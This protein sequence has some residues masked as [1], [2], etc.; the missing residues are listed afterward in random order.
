MKLKFVLLLVFGL[1]STIAANPAVATG[2]AITLWQLQPA[3]SAAQQPAPAHST[4]HIALSLDPK[5]LS[6]IKAQT[7]VAIAVPLFHQ[8]LQL[9]VNRV[10][11]HDKQRT[12]HAANGSRRMI[13]TTDGSHTFATVITERGNWSISGKDS[14]AM[15]YQSHAPAHQ[16]TTAEKDYLIAPPQQPVLKKKRPQQQSADVN[17][18]TVAIVDAYILYNDAAAQLYGSNSGALTRINHI[19][20]V[21]NDI[22]R[23]SNVNIELNALR[24]DKVDYPQSFNTT[25]ALNHATGESE[26]S[27]FAEQ[28]QIRDAI[29]ADV[30]ILLRPY[31]DDGICGQAWVNNSFNSTYYMVSHTSIDC[32][33]EVNAHELG[34]NMGLL[35][36]RKQG[37][38]G[39][40]F[41]FALGHGVDASFTTVMAYP[42]AFDGAQRLFK[43]SSPDLDCSGQPCG[44]DRN[45]SVNGADAVYALN[46][47]RFD[48][49]AVAERGPA[50][51]SLN[52]ELTGATSAAIVSSSGHGGLAPYT[53]SQLELGS[54][55]S[56]SA[57]ASADGVPFLAW[58][59]CDSSSGL[60]CS[61]TVRGI[62]EVSAIYSEMPASLAEAVDA[63]QLE[64]ISAGAS[65]WQIDITRSVQGPASVR[66]GVIADSQQSIMQTSVSGAGTLSFSWKVSSEQNFDY[67]RLYVDGILHRDISGETDWQ[68]VTL[69]LAA[70]DHQL[71][72]AYSKD[73]SISGGQDAGW[74]DNVSWQPTEDQYQLTLAKGGSG[75]GSVTLDPGQ[76]VCDEQCPGFTGQVSSNSWIYLSANANSQSQFAGWSGACAGQGAQCQLF[77]EGDISTT[78]LFEQLP[79]PAND[80]FANAGIITGASGSVATAN[81]LATAEANDP[82]IDGGSGKTLWWRWTADSNGIARFNTF[83][84]NFNTVLAV[85]QGSSL[86]DLTQLTFND[87]SGVSLNSSVAFF[88]NA[89][90]DYYILVDGMYTGAGD[91]ELYWELTPNVELNLTIG[92][93]GA[94]TVQLPPRF[95]CA[96]SSCVYSLTRGQTVTLL[97]QPEPGSNFAGWSGAC[98]GTGNCQ[99]SI[100][101][102]TTVNAGFALNQ[103]PLS[104]TVGDG[105][106]ISNAPT[107]ITHGQNAVFS[108]QPASG[109]RV[110]RSVSGTCPPGQWLDSRTYQTGAAGS[111]CSVSFSFSKIPPRKFPLWLLVMPQDDAS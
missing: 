33:D 72:W 86:A 20:A 111:A 57:P 60:D 9:N 81:T 66:S 6:A 99:F 11:V 50:Y 39:S 52:V 97:A 36:S 91:I 40:T 51:G 98:S 92:G 3:Q 61:L 23:A 54:T 87:N 90:A 62:A 59:G 56:L 16:H 93:D 101:D 68:Q 31:V 46:Q 77:V 53:L 102:N 24:I 63:P 78:V 43:F 34:H 1:L 17:S 12:L 80:N 15:M 75:A 2:Q 18:D 73:N 69:D 37:D 10:T 94:G 83:N 104:V 35:H 89:G 109:Y 76:T 107:L 95:T 88:T 74:V 82:V 106:S 96:D 28:R 4:S 55:V 44:V 27:Y 47:K 45:D 29:G 25:Q 67:L 110:D 58:L 19:V 84:S 41:P 42:S 103:Y 26:Q 48:I 13:L 79:A 7:S 21:T 30:M 49:A 85:Y 5:Q 70:G 38:T 22:Y 32:G 65:E 71:R 105:G 100:T 64:F 8:P 108:L 14:N